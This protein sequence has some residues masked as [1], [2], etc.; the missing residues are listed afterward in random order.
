M[1]ESIPLETGR[2]CQMA[3]RDFNDLRRR[4]RDQIARHADEMGSLQSGVI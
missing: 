4:L 1:H 3:H 2:T